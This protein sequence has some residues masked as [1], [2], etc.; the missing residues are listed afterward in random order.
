DLPAPV[1]PEIT[2]MPGPNSSSDAVTTAKS[3]MAR[4]LSMAP[5]LVAAIAGSETPAP[6]AAPGAAGAA[7]ADGALAAGRA[8]IRLRP[9]LAG[10]GGRRFNRGRWRTRHPTPDSTPARGTCCAR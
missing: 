4:R 10:R 2:V 9:R 6:G 5:S 8:H 3:R 1:S 7:G